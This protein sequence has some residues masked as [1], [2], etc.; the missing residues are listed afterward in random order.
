GGCRA[1]EAKVGYQ[2]HVH[3]DVEG[4]QPDDK[5]GI[6]AGAAALQQQARKGPVARAKRHAEHDD[7]ENLPASAQLHA[8]SHQPVKKRID[9]D[10][11]QTNANHDRVKHTA[12]TP[13]KRADL[14]MAAFR[15][16]PANDRVNVPANGQRKLG[17][18]FSHDGCEA[19]DADC[20][21]SSEKPKHEHVYPRVQLQQN[22]AEQT[23]SAE[24]DVFRKA[25]V[26][27]MWPAQ[28]HGAPENIGRES[29]EEH[30]FGGGQ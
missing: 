14:V 12:D 30:D 21:V 18:T 29:E 25:L 1:V 27:L 17:K 10:C 15:K 24:R 6:T 5:S 20:G 9:A 4:H 26:R 22:A 13:G 7:G 2:Q 28:W 8:V 16:V 19:E 23:A 11:D 3:D